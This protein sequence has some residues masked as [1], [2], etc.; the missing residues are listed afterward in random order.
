MI[1]MIFF[2]K[3]VFV[4]LFALSN[5]TLAE[6]NYP[7]NHSTKN[8]QTTKINN[9]T[10]IITQ[11]KQ[12]LFSGT[13][14]NTPLREVLKQVAKHTKL[15]F[16]IYPSVTKTYDLTFSNYSE[17]KLIDTLTKELNS[18]RI[19]AKDEQGVNYTKS[20][21]LLSKGDKNIIFKYDDDDFDFEKRF[22]SLAKAKKI[23]TPATPNILKLPEVVTLLK[24]ATRQKQHDLFYQRVVN[25]KQ[26]VGAYDFKVRYSTQHNMN[27]PFEKNG[28]AEQGKAEGFMSF[29][30]VAN[31]ITKKQDALEPWRSGSDLYLRFKDK[32]LKDTYILLSGNNKKMEVVQK[33]GTKGLP[34]MQARLIGDKNNFSVL[35]NINHSKGVVV[36]ADLAELQ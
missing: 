34:Q 26:P 21:I 13:L 19:L 35:A 4:L 17:K 29:I 12:G 15:K 11:D 1:K 8:T 16:F 28:K 10:L 31:A 9:H 2:L 23:T 27:I 7:D 14:K 32:K 5:Q 30:T 6:F 22:L 36:L 18:Y 3:L 24:L 33:I 20:L 25:P